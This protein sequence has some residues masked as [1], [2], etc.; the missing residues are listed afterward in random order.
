MLT[1][2]MT[3]QDLINRAK[4]CGAST[5]I[6]Y[7]KKDK[8]YLEAK[9]DRGDTLVFKSPRITITHLGILQEC[10]FD[11]KCGYTKLPD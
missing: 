10:F 3:G 8:I 11:L 4:K 6:L 2:T 5:H 9:T 1:L 7:D